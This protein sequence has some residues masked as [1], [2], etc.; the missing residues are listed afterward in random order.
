MS[1][2]TIMETQSWLKQLGFDPKGID[3]IWGKNS[4][5]ALES[6]IASNVDSNS[7]YG[8][9]TVPWGRKLADDELD[10]LAQVVRD[11]S[12]PKERISDLMAC[13]AW[14]SGE[15]FSPSVRNP[16]ST[17]TGLIQFISAT[18]RGLGTTTDAL[19]RMTVVQ[20]LDYVQAYFKPYARR[21]KNLGDLYMAILYPV[22]VGKEDGFVL[23][24]NVKS[25]RAYLA[26]KGLDINLD[27]KVTR[28]ECLHKVRNKLVK[29]HLPTHARGV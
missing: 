29:G 26:N 16:L 23:F 3:G 12:W 10:K 14:E 5:H 21:I 15:T 17:A 27:G 28:E 2:K 11:L 1:K 8:V 22:G 6:L 20:Q 7:V 4:R 24:D 25:N 13:I 19:S 9:K 18:A